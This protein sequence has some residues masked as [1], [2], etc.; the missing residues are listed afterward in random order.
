VSEI[1]SGFASL[2]QGKAELITE[3]PEFATEKPNL[4]WQL[5]QGIEDSK[6]AAM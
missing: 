1:L 6:N 2:K 3:E 5:G 4:E